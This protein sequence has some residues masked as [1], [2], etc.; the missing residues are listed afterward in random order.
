[1]NGNSF[2]LLADDDRDDAELFSEAL[3]VVDPA[4]KFH[5]VENG[6]EVFH[7]LSKQNEGK[8]D[9]IF[10]DLN[11]PAMSGWQCLAKLKNDTTLKEIPVIMYSTSSNPRE[12]EIAI[13]LGAVG[14]ITKPTDFKVLKR[15]LETIS[16]NIHGDLRK[17]LKEMVVV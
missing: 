10:L 17:I 13:E 15:I 12:K 5:H 16:D 1:M 4:I 9:L 11:M 3:V 6:H 2:F 7:F 14:F 8:P